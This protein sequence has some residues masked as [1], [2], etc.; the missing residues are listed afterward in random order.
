MT[1]KVYGVTGSMDTIHYARIMQ[2]LGDARAGMAVMEGFAV[3][4]A[5]L[6]PTVAPGRSLQA[7]TDLFS[8]AAFT[9]PALGARGV[10]P[11]IDRVV[12]QVDFNGNIDT[13]G[14]IIV[15]P[16][17]AAAAGGTAVAPQ[18]LQDPI[19]LRKWQ[20][21]LWRFLVP[22]SGAVTIT[23]ERPKPGGGGTR[24]AV[25]ASRALT[26]QLIPASTW[27]TILFD[28]IDHEVNDFGGTSVNITG[29][30]QGLFV[31]PVPGSYQVSSQAHFV[32][33]V[34]AANTRRQM[35]MVNR[36]TAGA[37]RWIKYGTMRSAGD[38]F[39]HV[40]FDGTVDV[41]AGQ[42]VE[43]QVYHDEN[44]SVYLSDNATTPGTGSMATGDQ[45]YASMTLLTAD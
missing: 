23:D 9:T 20:T 44:H 5:G 18:L 21:P 22:P 28:R 19:G 41:Q 16:G 14:S 26:R 11:R 35:R 39:D 15:V 38:N 27:T 6:T 24:Y 33:Q 31:G 2:D 45:S 32:N 42:T 1:F 40:Q 30:N 43:L 7:G 37:I 12:A 3:T 13:A 25:R 17:R 36:N 29:A 10:G 34:G 8:D 4:L